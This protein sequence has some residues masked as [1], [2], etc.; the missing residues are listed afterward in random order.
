MA[1]KGPEEADE[2]N[3]L[4]DSAETNVY[5][6]RLDVTH[7]ETIDKLTGFLEPRSLD[8][9]INNAGTL[10][11]AG[12]PGDFD[13]RKMLQSFEVNALGPLRVVEATLPALRRG[14]NPRIVN[15]T[16]K[17]GSM[18]D[19]N[20][21]GSY[22]YRMSKAALNMATRSLAQDLSHED[23]IAFVVHPGW[24]QTRMGGP[25]ALIDAE[26]SVSNMLELIDNATEEHCGRFWEWNGNEIPW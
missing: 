25:S 19:N 22:A 9:V 12:A 4:A 7:Q 23:V 26:T 11:R 17:M 21:G 18:A 2:L 6:L 1:P 3:A 8:V 16:S 5:V 10:L 14:E 20:S 15:V 13:Y 24:V